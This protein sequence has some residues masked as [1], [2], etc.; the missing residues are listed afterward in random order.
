MLRQ[1]DPWMYDRSGPDSTI[2]V[3]DDRP[4]RDMPGE[5]VDIVVGRDNG[6]PGADQDVHTQL[7]AVPGLSITTR[8]RLSTILCGRAL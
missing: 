2:I 1:V 4:G 5:I 7:D 3:G 8:G 6:H